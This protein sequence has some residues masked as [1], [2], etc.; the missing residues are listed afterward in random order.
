LMI[1]TASRSVVVVTSR[2]ATRRVALLARDIDEA[3]KLTRDL[4]R[5]TPGIVDGALVGH[6]DLG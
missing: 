3:G 6:G 1:A 5:A 4:Y 2:V